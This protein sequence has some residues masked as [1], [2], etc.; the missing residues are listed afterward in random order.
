MTRQTRIFDRF[1]YHLE[2]ISCR[3]CLHYKP[4]SR[5]RKNGCGR[6][7]CAYEDIRRACIANG[8][9]KRKRGFFK[10]PE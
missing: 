7:V 8:R 4:K 2:D 9:V 1:E 10:C 6:A 5:H 3:D